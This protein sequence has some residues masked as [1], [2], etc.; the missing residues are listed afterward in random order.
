MQADKDGEKNV[1]THTTLVRDLALDEDENIYFSEG[2][3]AGADGKIYRLVPATDNAPARGELFCTVDPRRVSG[4]WD[5]IFAFGRDANGKVD[6]NT[7]YLSTGNTVPAYIFRTTRNQ[8]EWSDPTWVYRAP[9]RIMG[10]VLTSPAAALM[11]YGRQHG[12]SG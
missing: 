4:Y 11:F 3:G 7:L 9:G 2:T 10:L 5:G 12:V 8:G 6:I 1:F